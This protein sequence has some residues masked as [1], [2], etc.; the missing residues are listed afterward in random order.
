MYLL[1]AIHNTQGFKWFCILCYSYRRG[2]KERENVLY[3]LLNVTKVDSKYINVHICLYTVPKTLLLPYIS[4]NIFIWQCL[5]VYYTFKDISSG[6]QSPTWWRTSSEISDLHPLLFTHW[7]DIKWIDKLLYK[8]ADPS[9][10]ILCLSEISVPK[11]ACYFLIPLIAVTH[12][13]SKHM[14]TKES[15]T[16]KSFVNTLPFLAC[17]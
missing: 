14:H 9:T 6:V 2:K 11:V 3:D 1:C 7:L 16:R 12:R 13:M 10:I 17:I 8:R 5:F 4:I 15:F